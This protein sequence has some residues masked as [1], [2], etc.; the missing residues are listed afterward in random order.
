MVAE[1]LHCMDHQA[2]RL[3]FLLQLRLIETYTSIP[4]DT[5][6][7]NEIND[8]AKKLLISLEKFRAL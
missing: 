7:C 4:S 8:L 6:K 2:T 1:H 3:H 5:K